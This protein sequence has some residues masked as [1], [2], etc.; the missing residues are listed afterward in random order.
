[1]RQAPYVPSTNLEEWVTQK[2][3]PEPSQ[4]NLFC[5]NLVLNRGENTVPDCKQNVVGMKPS[6]VLFLLPHVLPDALALTS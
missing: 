1:M 2:C 4:V 5:A 6:V 3:V